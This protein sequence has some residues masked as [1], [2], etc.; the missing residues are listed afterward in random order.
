MCVCAAD[1]GWRQQRTEQKR[2]Y[3]PGSSGA[4]WARLARK[5]AAQQQ[6]REHGN[7]ARVTKP[8]GASWLPDVYMQTSSAQSAIA[9]LQ[10]TT[11]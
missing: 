4:V 6:R 3:R 10:H 5:E 9:V 11:N 1:A 8:S 2:Q 7:R